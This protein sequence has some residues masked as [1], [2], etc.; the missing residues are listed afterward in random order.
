M[1]RYLRRRVALVCALLV[2]AIAFVALSIHH[3]RIV[4][5]TTHI[6]LVIMLN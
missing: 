1:G 5:L 2:A 6:S 3:Q 4:R